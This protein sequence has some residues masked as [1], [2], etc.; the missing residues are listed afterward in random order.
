M[1]PAESTFPPGPGGDESN[2]QGA[3]AYFTQTTGVTFPVPPSYTSV[4]V[5]LAAG[6][7][8]QIGDPFTLSAATVCGAMAYILTYDTSTGAY[9]TSTT[10]DATLN[11]GQGAWAYSPSGGSLILVP[12]SLPPGTQPSGPQ[13][14]A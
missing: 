1:L 14:A 9:T 8:Q 10:P 6:Q 2:G 5:A 7:W 13:C 11:L 4:S 3:W 12:S